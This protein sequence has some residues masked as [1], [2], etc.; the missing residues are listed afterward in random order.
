MNQ[1]NKIINKERDNKAETAIMVIQKAHSILEFAE[2]NYIDFSRR[3]L[4]YMKRIDNEGVD[5]AE[6]IINFS[7]N[8]YLYVETSDSTVIDFEIRSKWRARK[9]G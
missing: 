8:H 2:N 3:Y 5:L 1:K 6:F 4:D 9:E 7:Y